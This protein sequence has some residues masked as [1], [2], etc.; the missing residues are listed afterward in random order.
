MR[1]LFT[2]TERRLA[3]LVN[4]FSMGAD[5]TAERV[6][7]RECDG[8]GW[9]TETYTGLGTVIRTDCWSCNGEGW[10]DNSIEAQNRRHRNAYGI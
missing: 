1:Q 6:I 8:H 3:H 2:A 4:E 10:L 9:A 5:D 7:C